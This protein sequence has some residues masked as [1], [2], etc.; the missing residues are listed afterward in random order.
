MEARPQQLNKLLQLL[1]WTI[2]LF[3][4]YLSS[5]YN[6]L[7]YHCLAELFSVVI[8]VG[9][10]AIAWN[11]RRF[12]ENNYLLY[13]GIAYLFVGTIDLAHTLS[14]KGM[15][16][17]PGFGANLPTQLWIAAR[18]LE[19]V[20]L[21][22]APWF[23]RRRLNPVALFAGYFLI[24][25]LLCL[26]I[27]YWKVF[28]VC[29]VEGVGLTPFKKISEY[30]ICGILAGALAF[31]WRQRAEF[32]RIVLR[33]IV[34]SIILTMASELAFTFYVGVYDLSNFIGHFLKILSFYL[35]YK[36]IIET[37]L[38][39]P[40]NLLF[41]NLNLSEEA[42]RR[43]TTEL[44]FANRELESFSYSVSHDLKAP[45]RAIGGFARILTSDHADELGPEGL[46]LLQVIRTN[47]ELMNALIDDLLALARLGRVQI[48]KSLV[49]LT[50]MTSQVFTQLRGE[51]P[52]RDL[53][54]TIGDLPPALGDQ[55]LLHQVMMNLLAN[56]VKFTKS[57]KSAVIE[58]GGRTEDKENIYYVKDN[59]A[60]FDERYISK[61]FRP[62]QRLHSSEEF[63]GTGVGLALVKGII[64]R[65]GGR[66][67]AEGKAGEGA[68]FYFSLPKNGA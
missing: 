65:H 20:S 23:L 17:F 59:G 42:L 49:N 50:A 54:L 68:T 66:V 32:D 36:A 38:V 26:S 57:R 48:R 16:I 31:L 43:R 44:E 1:I 41:R 5:L 29:F 33:L 52:T 67:W 15:M 9:V 28:P 61:L 11:S 8:A 56:A 27:F 3:G 34:W 62:F 12:L 24:F 35:I 39:K 53:R 63:E 46:R 14:Y 37:G 2:V 45:V 21:L 60:G 55:S 7:L 10:F 30:I 4:L 18:Y 64:H 19:A 25:T 6:Y 40:Y 47:T 58:V 51:T 22:L 13:L